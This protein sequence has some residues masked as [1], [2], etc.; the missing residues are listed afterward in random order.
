MKDVLKV[1]L[2]TQQNSVL[3]VDE[4]GTRIFGFITP[5][6]VVKAFADAVESDV[7]IEDWLRDR[8]PSADRTI[9]SD[10]RLDDAAAIMTNRKVDHLVVLHPERREVVGV[11]SSLEILL[12]TRADAP[13]LRSMPLWE[14]PSVAEVL[15]QNQS[16]T[17]TCPKGCT[18]GEAADVLTRSARTSTIVQ[19]GDEGFRCGLLT[20]NDIVRAYIEG[21]N[22][23]DIVES[24]MVGAE[25]SYWQALPSTPVTEAASLL[26]SAAEPHHTCHHLVVKDSLGEWLGVFSALDLA[27]ALNSLSS[28]LDIAKTGVEETTVGM[29]MKLLEFL[30]RCEP[31]DTIRDAL[32][33]FD[34]SGQNGVLVE[35][36]E[37]VHGLITPRCAIEALAREVPP[38]CTVAAWLLDSRRSQ[39]APR[40]VLI[41]T[42]LANAANIMVTHALHHLLVVEQPG[43]PPM[44]VLSSLD[45]ARGI[46]SINYHCPFMSL[47]WLRHFVGPT[48]VA[49]EAADAEKETGKHKRP[50]STVVGDAEASSPAHHRQRLE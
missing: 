11:V 22:R 13:L 12:R 45:L 5:R 39:E 28:E 49:Q 24:W 32:T 9:M 7:K 2:V 10:S 34:I 48:S 46:V 37:K 14:G 38:S 42:S 20:E 21:R 15:V 17:W 41:N 16:L 3:V 36:D 23:S 43:G 19:I 44:G 8:T 35:D 47:S 40:E 29:V 26:L 18:F 27:R 4:A 31:T 33:V 50:G 6:D 1:L 30:P 25:P